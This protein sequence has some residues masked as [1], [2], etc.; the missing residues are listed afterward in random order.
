MNPRVDWNQLIQLRER[1]QRGA[2][3][4]VAADRRAERSAAAETER[5][6][7]KREQQV[8]YRHHHIEQLRGG[9]ESGR[10]DVVDCLNTHHSAG[11]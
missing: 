3:E 11:G 2:Q 5:A 6:A 8:A 7:A 10:C 4:A 1:G 9:V